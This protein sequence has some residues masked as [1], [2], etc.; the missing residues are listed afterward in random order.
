MDLKDQT[1]DGARALVLAR[2]KLACMTSKGGG[3]GCPIQAQAQN[4]TSTVLDILPHSLSRPRSFPVHCIIFAF[5]FSSTHF[6][7][8][9]RPL[10]CCSLQSP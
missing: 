1:V 7:L 5:F 3:V 9:L 10:E 6:A 8:A 4:N 2:V